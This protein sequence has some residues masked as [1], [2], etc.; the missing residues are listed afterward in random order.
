[1]G[2][3]LKTMTEQPALFNVAPYQVESDPRATAWREPSMES[4]TVGGT[5]AYTV[6]LK[7]GQ[8]IITGKKIGIIIRILDNRHISA[9]V[10]GESQSRRICASDFEMLWYGRTEVLLRR[11][12]GGVPII[13]SSP[14]LGRE[15]KESSPVPGRENYFQWVEPYRKKHHTY[16]RYCYQLVGSHQNPKSKIHIPGGGTVGEGRAALVT[17]AIATKSPGE[18]EQLIRQWQV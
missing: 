5:C 18:I 7:P 15:N 4:E 8:M 16:W 2:E 13:E 1:M 9:F 12:E 11:G 10:S 3:F 6:G 17:E 14:V